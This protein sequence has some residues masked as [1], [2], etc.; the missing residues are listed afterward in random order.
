MSLERQIFFPSS[1]IWL[2]KFEFIYSWHTFVAKYLLGLYR[3]YRVIKFFIAWTNCG[4]LENKDAM[5]VFLKSCRKLVVE[6]SFFCFWRTCFFIINICLLELEKTNTFTSSFEW[7][8]NFEFIYPW[9]AYVAK[10][11][12]YLFWIF[13]FIGWKRHAFFLESFKLYLDF[14]FVHYW[15]AFVARCL[16]G[17]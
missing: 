15:L 9:L 8:L 11:F 16:V 5:P 7:F 10:C 14:E 1:F 12:A 2:L 17:L 6:Y 13:K 4:C 3:V